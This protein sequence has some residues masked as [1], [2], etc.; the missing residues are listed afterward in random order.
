MNMS[1]YWQKKKVNHQKSNILC[2][3]VI[4]K[5][6]AVTLQ[7]GGAAVNNV[8]SQTSGSSVSSAG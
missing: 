4:F 5:A 3:S 1:K 2:N 6:C 7:K 8:K